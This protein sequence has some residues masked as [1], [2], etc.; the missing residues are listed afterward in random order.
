MLSSPVMIL[1]VPAG[2]LSAIS[3]A[4]RKVVSG[5]NG[6]GLSTMVQPAHQRRNDF[7]DCHHQREVPRHNTANDAN[8]HAPVAVKAGVVVL[9]DLFIKL[10][11]RLRSGDTSSAKDLALGLR[12]RLALLAGQKAVKLVRILLDRA[13]DRHACSLTLF[14][15][16]VL[17][18]P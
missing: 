6:D 13:R 14:E 15:R 18:R 16:R 2:T 7:L 8:R 12:M 11:R 9:D 4:T 3:S 5:V 17:P 10:E 1:T